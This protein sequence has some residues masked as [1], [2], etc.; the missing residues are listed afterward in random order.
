M[1]TKRI[2]IV[3]ISFNQSRYLRQAIESILNQNY[4]NLEYIIV[5]PGSTD[6]S[7]K[8]IEE[9]QDQISKIIYKADSGP[10]EGLNN[11]FAEATG[12]I[13]GYLNSDDIIYP[14]VLKKVNRIFSKKPN[15]DVI[16]AYGDVIN[17]NNE[18]QKKIFSKKMNFKQYLYGNCTIVQPSSF[19]KSNIFKRVGGF[20]KNNNI[21]WDGELMFEFSKLNA[22]FKVIHSYW[23]GFRLYNSSISGSNLYSSR[24]NRDILRL[25]KN[26]NISKPNN[27]IRRLNWLYSWLRNPITLMHRLIANANLH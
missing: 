21:A 14:G 10:A 17:E 25:Q 11:G 9:Y 4:S 26:N 6:G 5:D 12:E 23:S 18:I 2:S 8:V 7:R 20:N 16:S 22:S 24:F 27:F 19:F 13:Y 1:S 3:T 15:I